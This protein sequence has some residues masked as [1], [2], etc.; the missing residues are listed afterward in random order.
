MVKKDVGE[1]NFYNQLGCEKTVSG[2][3][4]TL[5]CPLSCGKRLMSP[6]TGFPC[7]LPSTITH[8]WSGYRQRTRCRTAWTELRLSRSTCKYYTDSSVG[9][10]GLSLSSLEDIAPPH[11]KM[12]VSV[13]IH[14]VFSD[15]T[16]CYI[17]Y[18]MR[19]TASFTIIWLSQ[20]WLKV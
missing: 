13:R 8:R 10:S 3:T 20:V 2:S 19:Q 12:C 11:Y 14:S 16:A 7:L 15:I 5:V 4:W 17:T 9:D 18:K 1:T 6:Q